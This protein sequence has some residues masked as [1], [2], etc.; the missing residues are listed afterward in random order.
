MRTVKNRTQQTQQT[1][2]T[3]LTQLLLSVQHLPQLLQLPLL[4]QVRVDTAVPITAGVIPGTSY[5]VPP[6]CVHGV[7]VVQQYVQ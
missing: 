6:T 1:E 4:L 3:Q 2:L 7:T 5:K